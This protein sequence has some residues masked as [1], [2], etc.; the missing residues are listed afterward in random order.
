MFYP[1]VLQKVSDGYVV[2]VP[3]I[4]G[5]YSAGDTLEEAY[6][7]AKEAIAFH[8]E[9]LVKDGE[10]IPKPTSIENHRNNPDFSDEGLFFGIVDVDITHLMGKAEKINITVPAYLLKRIDDFVATHK[11]YKNRSQFLS[12]IAADKILAS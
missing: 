6:E 1:L 2:L 9:E 7:N 11:E 5:C 4:A 8:L 3:D 12:K 10:E